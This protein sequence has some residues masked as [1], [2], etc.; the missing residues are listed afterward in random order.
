MSAAIV[1]TVGLSC[2]LNGTE[3]L[4]GIT[5]SITAGDYVGLVG[6]NGSGKTTLLKNILH[7]I[8]PTEGESFLFGQPG[9]HFHQWHL[10]GFLP[11]TSGSLTGSFPAT[12]E[13]VVS[14]GVA[15]GN[16]RKRRELLGRALMRLNLQEIKGR[17]IGELSGGQKQRV[18]LA[19]ALVNEPRLLFLDEPA[20][21]LDPESRENFFA[22]LKSLNRQEGVTI[23]LVTH[24]LG[25]IGSYASR[26]LYL[27]RSVLFFGSFDSFC[28][29]AEMTAYFG[30]TSQHLICHQHRE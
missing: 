1:E 17:L 13:E 22:L 6:P 11:Q 3:I 14:M 29:S 5:L 21:A 2:R 15:A 4:S 28:R 16:F 26:L 30:Q 7:L 25:S 19:R 10:I 12:V 9:R 8:P 23:I 20:T 24:D 27:N 18:L